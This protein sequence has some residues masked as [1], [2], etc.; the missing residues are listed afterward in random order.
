MQLRK[1]IILKLSLNLISLHHAFKVLGNEKTIH[2]TDTA[3]GIKVKVLI[4]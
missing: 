3:I 2:Q 1:Q 4:H